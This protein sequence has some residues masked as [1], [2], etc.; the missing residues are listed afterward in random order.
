MRLRQTRIRVTYYCHS[1]NATTKY[2]H[3]MRKN[4]KAT[5]GDAKATLKRHQN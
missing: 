2:R 5:K 1:D 3:K 4:L